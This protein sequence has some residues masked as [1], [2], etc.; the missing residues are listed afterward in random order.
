MQEMEENEDDEESDISTGPDFN[1]ILS[2]PLW[3]L[4]KEKKD[5]L[6]KQRDAKVAISCWC[7]QY[8]E[9]IN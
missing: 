9:S 6:C 1:Y 8:E 2:M 4:T 5:E 3:N 7:S